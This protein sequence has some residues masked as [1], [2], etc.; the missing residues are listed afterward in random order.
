MTSATK[1]VFLESMVNA[2]LERYLSD[3]RDRE[4]RI[5]W[6][7][8]QKAQTLDGEL[9]PVRD[10]C[11]FEWK[12]GDPDPKFNSGLT[13]QDRGKIDPTRFEQAFW[14]LRPDFRFCTPNADKQ[15]IIE[16]KG[17]RRGPID[18]RQ[19][20]CYPLY[21]KESG[22]TGAVIYLVPEEHA[23]R[24][25]DWLRKLPGLA[26]VRF[27]VLPW[28]EE[29]LAELATELVQAIAESMTSGMDLLKRAMELRRQ[30]RARSTT[31]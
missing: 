30:D 8:A 5:K 4:E 16:G 26:E 25:L 10:L 12:H 29:F 19:A 18:K 7:F 24:W 22:A 11:G 27:G 6:L 14:N 13:G 3:T 17:G 20:E 31:V 15:L 21:V 9:V 23:E 1:P 28:R 2:A